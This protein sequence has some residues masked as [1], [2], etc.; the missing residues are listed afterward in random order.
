MDGQLSLVVSANETDPARL[1][2]ALALLGQPVFS[3]DGVANVPTAAADLCGPA[4]SS[5][6]RQIDDGLKSPL[7]IQAAFGVER[8]LPWKTTM[9][10]F[11]VSSRTTNVFRSR[12]IN[13][14]VCPEQVGCSN[15]PRPDPT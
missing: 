5:T 13:A 4:A 11:F 3:Q 8:Q 14:P 6:L 2:A 1:A 7:M 15:A 10:A 9:G 12:N